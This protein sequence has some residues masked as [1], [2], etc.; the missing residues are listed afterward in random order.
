MQGDVSRELKAFLDMVKGI[1]D[2]DD[3]VKELDE[4]ISEVKMDS[5]ARREYMIMKTDRAIDRDIAKQEGRAEG[6]AEGRVEGK[7][8]CFYEL[9]RDEGCEEAQIF[10][11]AEKRFGMPQEEIQRI[12]RE[13]QIS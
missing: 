7:I 10:A 5:L 2:E 1:H 6:L 8:Q 4:A 13:C 9:R 11:E 12:I 3:F